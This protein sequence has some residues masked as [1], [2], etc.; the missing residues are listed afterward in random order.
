VI[1]FDGWRTAKNSGQISPPRVDLLEHAGRAARILRL[2]GP[3]QLAALRPFVDEQKPEVLHLH[4]ALLWP[5]ANELKE[6]LGLPVVYTTHVLQAHLAML[7][8]LE[9][10]PQSQQAED[11]VIAGCMRVLAPSP[12][13]M[14]L[15]QNDP[16]CDSARLSYAPL[17]LE[18]PASVFSRTPSEKR[19]LYVGRFAD[20]NGCAELC[21]I[22]LQLAERHREARFVIAG[23]IPESPKRERRWQRRFAAAFAELGDRVA[24]TGWLDR[25]QLDAQLARASLLIAPSWFETYGLTVM[26]A[27]QRATPIVCSDAGA[28][29]D[30]LAHDKSALLCSPKNVGCFVESVSRLLEDPS[31]AE[32]L[33]QAARAASEP[34]AWQKRVD[35]FIGAYRQALSAGSP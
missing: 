23:G 13:C 2:E 5:S 31:R 15:L 14:Q 34:H 27:A 4:D 24:L 12:C 28:L 6:A 26:E 32:A 8:G 20:V 18:P 25:A 9:S 30:W 1:S 29:S 35:A 19:V 17:G 16:R 33:G 11:V 3:D 21:E 22:I 7:R 10:T